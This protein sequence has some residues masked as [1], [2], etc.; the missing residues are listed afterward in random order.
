MSRYEVDSAQMTQAGAAVQRSAAAVR[1][2]V[3]L[4]QRHLTDLQSS[5]RGNAATGFAAI[6]TEWS[7][8][9]VRVEQAL[10]QI[11]AALHA[12]AQTYAD[13]E[14]QASRLFSS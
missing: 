3:A 5:W 11:T 13:A 7:A 6:M 10:D 12:A 14:Q 4:M 2:E 8:T 9:Q 1:A